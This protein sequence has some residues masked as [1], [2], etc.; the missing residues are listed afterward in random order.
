MGLRGRVGETL[1]WQLSAYDNRYRD[2][3]SMETVGGS[4][5]SASNPLTY[6]YIN[7]AKARIKGV[8]A[9]AVWQATRD[10]KLNASVAHANGQSIRNGVSTPLDTVQPTRAKLAALYTWG[11]WDLQASLQHSAAKKASQISSASYFATPSYTLLDLA[12]SWRLTPSLSVSAAINNVT[13]QTYWRWSDVRGVAANSNAL[14]AY[15]APG[16]N[17]ALALRAEF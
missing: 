1:Q 5:T 11:D 4:I 9:R 14:G 2:F 12:A 7:L 15:T 17:V 3:I 16:R 6:Q 10:L 8:E 13:D